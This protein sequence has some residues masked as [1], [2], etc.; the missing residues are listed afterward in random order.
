[1]FRLRDGETRLRGRPL[2]RQARELRL[3][4]GEPRLGRLQ[5]AGRVGGGD[6]GAESREQQGGDQR[7]SDSSHAHGWNV[8][9]PSSRLA[10][11]SIGSIGALECPAMDARSKRRGALWIALAANAVLMAA[12]IAGG[13]AFRSL[14]LLTDAV[15]LLTDVSGLGIALLAIGLQ[16]RPI[17]E[18]H[19][20]GLQRAE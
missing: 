5:V 13:F 14:A 4:R 18:R 16:A 10:D 2:P 11:G 19:T 12:E 7:E 17:T 3:E 9:D 20:F 8:P 6:T 1:E 15:H